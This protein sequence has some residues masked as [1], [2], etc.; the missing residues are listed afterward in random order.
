MIS[1]VK[2][3]L[4]KMTHPLRSW[5]FQLLPRTRFDY[6]R[7]VGTGHGSSV[8]MAPIKFI[9]RVF[10]EAPLRMR[11]KVGEQDQIFNDHDLI[12]LLRRPNDFYSGNSLW[13]AIIA[14]WFLQGNAY[15]IKI[16]NAFQ[17][18]ELWWIPPWLIG[19]AWPKDGST[20]ISHYEYKPA[21]GEKLKL[22][23]SSVIHLRNGLDP[24]NP[25][26]GMSDLYSLLREVFTDDEASNFT[27]SILRNSGVPGL[28]ISP[29]Q[30]TASGDDVLATKERF[31]QERTGD[32]RGEP[33]VMRGPTE[34]HQFAWSPAQMELGTIRDVSEERV[35]AT[36]GIPAAVVGFGTGLQQTKV[37][38][39]MRELVQLAWIGCILPTQHAFS[40]DLKVQLLPDFEPDPDNWDIFFDDAMVA[41]LQESEK[42]RAERLSIGV[43]GGWMRVDEARG[44][45]RLE[46]SEAD[47]IYLRDPSKVAVPVGQ[48]QPALPQRRL[49]GKDLGSA[50]I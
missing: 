38:A 16:R 2:N 42:E 17:P 43:D 19:P 39:T 11:R 7:E 15:L 25:R 9:Q 22:D 13:R 12:K 41:V 24:R 14:S 45:S 1:W 3:Q 37:G 18:V 5:L 49:N 44:A 10:P 36:I 35:C 34:V 27:A 20:F 26:V 48:K 46:V 31:M 47:K 28:I 4:R 8:V 6:A 29:K 33:L 40:E 30:G 50:T 21:G 32:R 23:P